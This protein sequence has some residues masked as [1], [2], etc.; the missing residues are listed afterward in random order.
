MD[1]EEA[2]D[3]F[4]NFLLLDFQAVGCIDITGIDELRV[5]ENEVKKRV[6]HLIFL[7][8]HLPVKQVFESSGLIKELGPNHM[9]ENREKTTTYLF[10]YL[11]HRYCR[12]DCP[13]C[14]FYNCTTIKSVN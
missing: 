12:T 13:Y 6:V 7:D 5:L 10:Q 9:I 11:D 2:Y 1:L 14:L 8:V 3:Y 4:N